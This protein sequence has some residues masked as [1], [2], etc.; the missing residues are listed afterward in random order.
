MMFKKAETSIPGCFEIIYKK[1]GDNRGSFTKTFH[2]GFFKDL[3]IQMHV[4]EEFFSTS[5]KGVFRGMHFQ[6]PPHAVAK[7]VY[8]VKGS[9]LDF[10]VDL[11]KGAP[12]FGK[13]LTFQL[14]DQNPRAI[15]IPEGLAHGFYVTSEIAVMNYKSSGVYDGPTDSGISYK[16][17]TFAEQITDPIISDRDKNFTSFEDFNNPFTYND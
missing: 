2:E 16:S 11:R 1:L 14:D 9:V 13:H 8:C 12:T 10:V 6:L 4:G 15:F 17:F 5:A 7:I 3:G